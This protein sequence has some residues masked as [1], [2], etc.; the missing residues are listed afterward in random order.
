MNAYN[1]R[2]R[3]AVF[4]GIPM[5]ALVPAI[6][7]AMLLLASIWIVLFLKLY[8]FSAILFFV[9]IVLLFGAAIVFVKKDQ[10]LL[11]PSIFSSK[12]ES[13]CKIAMATE[14]W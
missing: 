11:M 6:I 3:P 14:P 8:I 9:S 12:K 10:L 7:G 5:L 2:I 13:K 1:E 4:A